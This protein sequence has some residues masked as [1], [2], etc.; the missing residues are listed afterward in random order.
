MS[1]FS[2]GERRPA[3][4]REPPLWSAASGWGMVRRKVGKLLF[5][6]L[7]AMFVPGLPPWENAEG[8]NASSVVSNSWI[9]NLKKK[10]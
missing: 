5:P 2:R 10:S 9:E 7:T 4:G 3:A 1:P 6:V 8:L